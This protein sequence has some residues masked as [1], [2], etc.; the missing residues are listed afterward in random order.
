MSSFLDFWKP[1]QC[2]I[3]IIRHS[4]NFMYFHVQKFTGY[5]DEIV[6]I[7]HFSTIDHNKTGSFDCELKFV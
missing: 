5:V 6:P 1:R 3:E 7:K 2:P 4:F